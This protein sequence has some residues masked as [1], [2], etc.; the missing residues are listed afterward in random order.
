MVNGILCQLPLPGHIDEDTVTSA[1]IP[2]KDVDGFHPV[3]AG[4]LLSGKEGFLPCTPAGVMEMLHAYEIPVTGKRCVV[5]G[6]SNI[7]GKP[8]GALLLQ[9]SGTVTTC[10]S[11][12]PD[13]A[14]FTREADIWWPP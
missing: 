1:I 3:N 6:R 12:T 10:H 9:R 14:K 5:L 13:L 4:L 7:V 11:R 8:M 2:Q